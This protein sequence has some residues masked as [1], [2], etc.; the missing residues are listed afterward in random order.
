MDLIQA[1][2]LE[3]CEAD[4]RARNKEEILLELAR[5]TTRAEVM[6]KIDPQEIYEAL[7]ERE[8]KGSTGFG[9]GV[10]IPHCALEGAT[11]FVV[12]IAIHKRGIDFE[13]MDKKRVR[14]FVSIVGPTEDRT[15]H[16]QLLAQISR[17]LKEPNVKETIAKAATKINLYEEFLSN[18]RLEEPELKK[19]KAKLMLM[20]VRDPDI[21]D[22]LAG[23]FVEYG[24]QEVTIL[25]AQRME[26]ILSTVPLFLGFFD[27]TSDR[28]HF[29]K[30]IMA[31]I[32]ETRIGAVVKAIEDI[33]GDLDYYSGLSIQVIEL[34]F[35]KGQL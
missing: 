6:E 15:S 12:A 4:S 10:A 30:V 16:L 7:K 2:K 1:V 21:M 19:G 28:S 3:C 23:I 5:L 31:K 20:V 33:V 18:A 14:I 24:I 25:D 26:N 17:I 29:N 8:E 27:F 32:D 34:Y 9:G 13:A 22:D 35:S 11:D